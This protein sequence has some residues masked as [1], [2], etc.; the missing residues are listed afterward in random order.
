MRRAAR[1]GSGGALPRGGEPE[2]SVAADAAGARFLSR[3]PR[4]VAAI[5]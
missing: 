5:R 3:L 2:R 1:R 4:R